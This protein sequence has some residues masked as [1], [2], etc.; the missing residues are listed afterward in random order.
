MSVDLV[1]IAEELAPIVREAIAQASAPLLTRIAELEAK[2]AVF[3][4][5]APQPGRDGRDGLPGPA[6]DRGPAGE[7]GLDG[8]LGQPGTP[9]PPGPPGEQGRTGEPG[10]A[11]LNG[12]DGTPGPSGPSGERGLPGEKG[13]DG[14]PGRDGIALEIGDL[15]AVTYSDDRTFTFEFSRGEVTKTFAVVVPGLLLYRDVWVEGR[16]YHAGDVVT[17]GGSAWVA[18]LDTDAKP[19]LATEA[20]RAWKLAVKAGR[21]GKAGPKGPD[22]PRGPKGD[23]GDRGP[24]RW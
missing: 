24:E 19:G 22:G 2:V 14:A 4:V 13:L 11:G 21:E 17:W 9:G 3:E 15:R 18:L 6:G 7:K 12:Y 16:G 8:A 10:P 23:Q 1:S 5:R 20:S